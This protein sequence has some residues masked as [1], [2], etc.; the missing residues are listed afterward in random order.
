MTMRT[1]P[2]GTRRIVACAT[3]AAAALSLT[4]A[5]TAL[6]AP[7]G[8]EG[9]SPATL[10]LDRADYADRMA[11]M[12]MSECLANWTGLITEHDRPNGGDK[13]STA[14]PF[15][16]DADWG[17]EVTNS[18]G[19]LNTITW[20][21]PDP[22]GADDDTDIE[23]SY[24]HEMVESAGTVNLDPE[25]IAHMWN[26]NV[27]SFVWFSNSA[28]DLLQLSGVRTP[29]TSL[30]AS[31]QHR[32][33][34][35]AQLTTE[36]FGALAPGRPDAALAIAELPIRTSAGGFATHVAQ[37]NV[38]MFSLAPLADPSAEPSDQVRWL[39]DS[40][41]QYI[42]D[43][44]RA[45]EIVDWVTGQYDTHPG[46][47]WESLRDRIYQRY[48]HDSVAN[49]FNFIIKYESAINLAAEVAELLHGGGDLTRTI[50]IGTLFGWD[51]DNPTAT[52]AALLGLMMGTDQVEDA[53]SAEG[54][55]VVERFNAYRTRVNL[56]DYLPDDP[57][58]T[59]TFDMMGQRALSL[60][61]QTVQAVGGDV[62]AGAWT[63]P[64]TAAPGSTAIEDVATV[65][66]DADLYMS[67]G[68]NAV[69]RE[70]GSI[71]VSSDLIGDTSRYTTDTSAWPTGRMQ[72][73]PVNTD[74]L[75]V[76]A[77]GFDQDTRG[78][79]EWARNPFFTGAAE[80]GSDPTIEVT[81]DRPVQAH[82]I[83]LIGGGISA[84]TGWA[85]GATVQVRDSEDRWID[86]PVEASAPLNPAQ[87]FQQTDMVFEEPV[88]FSGFRVTF[89][90]V[91]GTLSVTELDPILAGRLAFHGFDVA[92]GLAVSI[93]DEGGVPSSPDDPV[94]V[95]VGTM[96]ALTVTVT[97]TGED[98]L[99]ALTVL[100]ADGAPI[101]A[102]GLSGAD[103]LEAGGSASFALSTTSVAGPFGVDVSARARAEDATPV[104]AAASWYGTGT[105]TEPSPTPTTP[106]AEPQP[107]DPAPS[108]S[109]SASATKPGTL[110]RTGAN[111]QI[112]A[113]IGLAVTAAGAVAV[114]LSR[115]RS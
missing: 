44:S 61:D 3:A 100:G 24:L 83:R 48:Q 36:L 57:E 19:E 54:I 64:L 21:N 63:I 87:P 74:D 112:L 40:A 103:G 106:T 4:V 68:N 90:G 60:V 84:G 58:A 47:N 109:P 79:E 73:T 32:N 96:L 85:T 16:T 2:S 114:G 89:N 25:D 115:R 22:C 66:P 51:A 82:G 45:A 102:A 77:D 31:N 55:S 99:H 65:N 11:A 108:A 33:I 41:R 12:W 37:F 38:A 113:V 86:V 91:E 92:H 53:L 52:N 71:A 6:A 28:A 15:Y 23:Y 104:T 105:E 34:I 69:L 7:E 8:L 110:A 56:T 76:V 1:G 29:S 98:A 59:D 9:P 94:D 72:P 10:T 43:G 67:S 78:L 46:E 17:T 5:T 101:M 26:T 70:G 80:P 42:P 18:A 111:A 35:D 62:G 50:Q 81:Y 93:A 20:T 95:P 107:S 88:D 14:D 27:E 97:N 39:I 49:G 30:S 75:T 13:Y